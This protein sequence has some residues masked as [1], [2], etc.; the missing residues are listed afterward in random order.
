MAALSGLTPAQMEKLTA[1]AVRFRADGDL[2]RAAACD[3]RV[4]ATQIFLANL[5]KKMA[6]RPEAA[7]TLRESEPCPGGAGEAGPGDAAAGAD[8][9]TENALDA[10]VEAG[11]HAFNAKDY[12][13]AAR[14]WRIGCGVDETGHLFCNVGM[15]YRNRDRNADARR[16]FAEGAARGSGDCWVESGLLLIRGRGGP[17]DQLAAVDAFE[18][19]KVARSPPNAYRAN[20]IHEMEKL[21]ATGVDFDTMTMSAAGAPPPRPTANV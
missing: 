1:A 14:V 15:C 9:L 6:A 3:M 5:M 7:E 12:A 18:R 4:I 19:A 17:R 10:L 8:R 2:R 13:L 16:Y 21:L 20:Q 11:S